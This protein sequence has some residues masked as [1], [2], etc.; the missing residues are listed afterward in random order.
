MMSQARAPQPNP[1]HWIHPGASLLLFILS[2]GRSTKVSC[3]SNETATPRGLKTPPLSPPKGRHGLPNP[4]RS[5]SQPTGQGTSLRGMEITHAKQRGA[6]TARRVARWSRRWWSPRWRVHTAFP[7]FACMSSLVEG[8]K[9]QGGQHRR[10]SSK[11]GEK[12]APAQE[13]GSS[14]PQATEGIEA[15]REGGQEGQ[16]ARLSV[17]NIRD[18]TVTHRVPLKIEQGPQAHAHDGAMMSSSTRRTAALL[19]A[20]VADTNVSGEWRDDDTSI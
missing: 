11:G 5:A 20:G 7:K 8:E 18:R 3:H 13:H 19:N 12:R 10:G 14:S 1:T 17:H 16:R 9:E 6:M 2:D 4:S 15:Y